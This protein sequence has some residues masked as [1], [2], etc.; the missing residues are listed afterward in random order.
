SPIM[1]SMFGFL[2]SAHVAV[3]AGASNASTPPQVN[4]LWFRFITPSTSLYFGNGFSVI[5]SRSLLH[6]FWQTSTKKRIHSRR[7]ARKKKLHQSAIRR[8]SPEALWCMPHQGAGVMDFVLDD[9]L[10][11]RRCGLH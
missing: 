1:T 8:R 4:S 2:S 7:S 5:S 10:S 6:R 9:D 11:G 3:A